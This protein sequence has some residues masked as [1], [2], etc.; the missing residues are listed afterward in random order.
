MYIISFK[1]KFSFD[2]DDCKVTDISKNDV[3]HLNAIQLAF[4]TQKC[5]L[6][7]FDIIIKCNNELMNQNYVFF[8]YKFRYI[9]LLE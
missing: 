3:K 9:V 7:I 4:D 2:K 6:S 8:G 5:K 1:L